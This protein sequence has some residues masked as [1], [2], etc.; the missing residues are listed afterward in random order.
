[1]STFRTVLFSVVAIPAIALAQSSNIDLFSFVMADA[2]LIA[3]VH[4]D[5]AKNSPFGQFVLSQIPAEGK[6]LHGIMTETGIDPRSDVTEVLVAWNG[7]PNSTGHWLAAARGTFGGSIETIEVNALKNGG[8]ITRLPGVD[9][10][11]AGQAGINPQAANVCIG[12]FTDGFT[13][14]IGDCTSVQAAIQFGLASSGPASSVGM[15]AQ[16]LRAQQD[17]W[18]ASVVPVSQFA[19]LVTGG[20]PGGAGNLGGILKNNLFQAIQQISGGVKFAS[21]AQGPA[22]QISAEVMLDSPQ[23]ATALLNVVNFIVGLVQMNTNSGPAAGGLAAVLGNLQASVSGSTL[24]IGLS[25]PESTLE[26][27]FEHGS[28]LAQNKVLEP[29]R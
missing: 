1:M 18:F 5:A 21:T 14:V 7:A 15:K 4:V 25:V 10:V 20:N 27:L 11:T 3:G 8:T 19:N 22:A 23:D 16:Q 17:V 6:F 29:N 24:N 2:Q 26:L 9:L 12:L 28:Q 13:D